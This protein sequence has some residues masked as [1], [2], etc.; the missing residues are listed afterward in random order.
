MK[1]VRPISALAV[2]VWLRSAEVVVSGLAVSTHAVGAAVDPAAVVLLRRAG[3]VAPGLLI[4]QT[5]AETAASTSTALS[6][7]RT[8]GLN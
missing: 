5:L 4:A 3:L 7:R 1:L 2:H 8:K 6:A